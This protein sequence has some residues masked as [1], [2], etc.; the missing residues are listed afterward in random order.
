MPEHNAM[1]TPETMRWHIADPQ[2][3]LTDHGIH[4]VFETGQRAKVR[5]VNDPEADHPMHHPIHFHGQRFYE[6]EWEGHRSEDLMW[7]DT[8]LVPTGKTVDILLDCSNPGRWMVHCHIAEHVEGGMM[9]TYHV[10]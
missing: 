9:L 8:V 5:I 2:S 4:W 7:K 1:S 10:E 3:G 6:L